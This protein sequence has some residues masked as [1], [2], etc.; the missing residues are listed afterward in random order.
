MRGSGGPPAAMLGAALETI[1]FFTS[2]NALL[3]LAVKR[4]FQ[5]EPRQ[6]QNC[7]QLKQVTRHAETR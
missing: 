3:S 6:C 7:N 4:P 1:Y 2:W 5:C